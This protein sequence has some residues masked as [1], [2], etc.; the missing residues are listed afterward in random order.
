MAEST[1]NNELD[2]ANQATI[3]SSNVAEVHLEESLVPEVEIVIPENEIIHVHIVCHSHDDVGWQMPP[4]QY[5]NMRVR[6]I[7]TSVVK[8]LEANPKRKFSQTEIYYFEMWWR[9]QSIEI[10]ERVKKLVKDGQLEF[11]NGGWVSNDEACP[12][13]EEVIMNM[14]TGHSFLKQNFDFVPKH[15]WHADAFGHSAATVELF[16]KMGFESI[17]FARIDDE[18]K[19]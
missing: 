10:K 3:G 19:N 13:Y 12:S 16:A 1:A 2:T 8:A 6:D 11:I 4:E 5:F 14:M 18:E 9:E 15:A 7:I 17:S